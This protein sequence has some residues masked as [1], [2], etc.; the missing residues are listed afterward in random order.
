[1][2]RILKRSKAEPRLDHG[3]AE[4]WFAVGR[5]MEKFIQSNK[6]SDTIKGGNKC[7]T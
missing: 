2:L 7:D 3:K 4:N 6:Q 1:M 5:E